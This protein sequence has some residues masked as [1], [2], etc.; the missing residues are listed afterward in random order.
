MYHLSLA[1]AES[2]EIH[3]QVDNIDI[4]QQSPKHILINPKGIILPAN[5]NLHIDDNI[6]P[7]KQH[8]NSANKHLECPGPPNSHEQA[9]GQHDSGQ[10]QQQRPFGGEI[11]GGQFGVEGQ[12]GRHYQPCYD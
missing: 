2:D 4:Q 6:R 8:S 12:P 10:A 7:H 11:V 9:Q 5:N 3:N 1:A